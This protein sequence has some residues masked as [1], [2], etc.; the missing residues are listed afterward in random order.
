MS[1]LTVLDVGHG[2][3]SVI[4]S[5]GKTVVVDAANRTHLLCYLESKGIKQIDLIVISHTDLDHVGGLIN[6]LS[7]PDL[8]V[9][10][11]VI[12]PDGQKKSKIWGDIRALVDGVVERGELDLVMSVV[13][14]KQYEWADVNESLCLEVVS[15]STLMAMSGPGL[16]LPDGQN[17]ITG[18][19]ASIVV[20]VIFN[21][22]PVV[23]VTADMDMI[24]LSEMQRCNVPVKADFLIFPHHGGLPGNADPAKF[25]EELI[26]MVEPKSVIFS[27]GRG[28]HGTPKSEIISIIKKCAPTPYIACTQLS[29]NCCAK[30]MARDDFKPTNYSAGVL[31]DAFCA[32]TI[33]IDLINRTSNQADLEAHVSFTRGLPNSLC[34]KEQLIFTTGV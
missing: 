29:L 24:S 6:V 2:S 22:T 14:G 15:P 17:V 10:R 11:L 7:S 12:N 5:E 13:A 19:S 16:R 23:L 8:V 4:S 3:C 32:G 31:D 20:R 26:A 34:G 1:T 25:T 28:L 18:N 30:P 21:G 33:E 27:N 9:K